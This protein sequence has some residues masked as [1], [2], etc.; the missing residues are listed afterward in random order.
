MFC[1]RACFVLL[2]VAW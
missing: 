2:T 1:V